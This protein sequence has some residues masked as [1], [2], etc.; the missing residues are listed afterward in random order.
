[1]T[2]WK[3][4]PSKVS[5]CNV[6]AYCHL[7]H[8][9]IQID[10]QTIHG[11]VAWGGNW[12]FLVHDHN[13]DVDMSNLEA[14]TGFAWRVRAM[15]AEVIEDTPVTGFSSAQ[16]KVRAVQTSRG[17]FEAGQVVAELANGVQP[18]F[19]LGAFGWR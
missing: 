8:V 9:P 13:L 10:G 7:A 19:D 5:V 11:D 17:E 2:W 16:G 15:G 4:Y 1:M 12:F 3:I 14:L 6:P 18:A